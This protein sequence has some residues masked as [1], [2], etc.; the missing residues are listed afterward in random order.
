MSQADWLLLDP[1]SKSSH[2]LLVRYTEWVL[3]RVP[4]P[5]KG[6]LQAYPLW[7]RP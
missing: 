5:Q 2:H 1:A 4:F 3:V 6:H 7:M